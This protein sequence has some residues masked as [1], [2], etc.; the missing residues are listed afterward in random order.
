MEAAGERLAKAARGKDEW[1]YLSG[2]ICSDFAHMKFR[3]GDQDENKIF[4][5]NNIKSHG[6]EVG[7]SFTSERST[8]HIF[9][10]CGLKH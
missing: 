6:P 2:P 10:N 8:T 4:F 9:T 1:N 5:A 3:R 7:S